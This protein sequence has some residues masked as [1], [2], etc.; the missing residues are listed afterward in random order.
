ML[1]R[2][3]VCYLLSAVALSQSLCIKCG[4]LLVAVCQLCP[5]YECALCMITYIAT[6]VHANFA[7]LM[8]VA[9]WLASTI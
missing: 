9:S 3:Y 4:L 7:R 2:E 5:P 6:H 8:H 1:T